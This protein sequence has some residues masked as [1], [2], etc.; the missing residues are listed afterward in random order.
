MRSSLPLVLSVTLLGPA[1]LA[2]CQCDDID[3][4]RPKFAPIATIRTPAD[5]TPFLVGDNV[6]VMGR[7]WS[8]YHKDDVT[9]T[10]RLGN[11]LVCPGTV[12]SSVPGGDGK[13]GEVTCNFPM[14]NLDRVPLTLVVVDPDGLAEDA[15]IELVRNPGGAPTATI[16]APV[17]GQRYYDGTLIELRGHVADPEDDPTDLSVA[18]LDGTTPLALQATALGSGDVLSS[19]AFTEGQHVLQLTVQDTMGN[20]AADQVIFDVGPPNRTPLCAIVAPEDGAGLQLGLPLTL[21]GTASDADI[22]ATALQVEWSSQL[23]GVLGTGGPVL[24]GDIEAPVVLTAGV[25]AIRLT[26]TDD[27]GAVCVDQITV[28]VGTP[29][30]VTITGPTPASLFTCNTTIDFTATISDPDEAPQ[31]LSVAWSSSMDGQMNTDPSDPTGS[32]A[33]QTSSLSSGAHTVFLDVTDRA[34]LTTRRSVAIAVNCAPEA[35]VISLTPASPTTTDTLQAIVAVAATDADGDPLTATWAWTRDGQPTTEAGPTVASALTSKNQTWAVTQQVTD[36]TL[37]ATSAPVSVVI[38]NT[39]PVA[40][41]ASIDPVALTVASSPNCLLSGVADAD[42]DAVT[43]SVVWW[44]DGVQVAT[45]TPLSASLLQRGQSMHCVATPTD[46]TDVGISH[47]SASVE[48]QNTLP[49]PPAV[50]ITPAAP[51][52]GVDDLWC[53]ISTPSM[54]ADGDVVAYRFTWT[55]DGTPLA[56]TSDNVLPGDLVPA[57]FTSPGQVWTCAVEASDGFG[58]SP[59]ATASVTTVCQPGPL[60]C[61][62]VDDDCDNSLIDGFANLDGDGLPDCIDDDADGDGSPADEDCDDFDADVRPGLFDIPND[63]TDQDCSGA[64]ATLCYIDGDL[65]GYGRDCTPGDSGHADDSAHDSGTDDTDSSEDCMVYAADGDCDDPGEATDPDDCDDANDA[66]SPAGDD[67]CNGVDDDC[68]GVED[69]GTEPAPL[70]TLQNGV[71]AGATKVCVAGSWTDPNY[72]TH[73]PNYQTIET[74]CDGWN[75]D[76]D[77]QTDENV[78]VG[79]LANLQAGVCAGARKVCL[80]GA[81]REPSYASYSGFYESTESS[82]DTRDNDCD[83]AVDENVK[84][85]W[86]ADLDGDSFGDPDNSQL[87]CNDPGAAWVSDNRDCDDGWSFVRPGLV[88]KEM[89]SLRSDL[90]TDNLITYNGDIEYVELTTRDPSREDYYRDADPLVLGYVVSH[91]GQTSASDSSP[92]TSPPS[93]EWVR[94]Q[95]LW[96]IDAQDPGQPI[97]GDHCVQLEGAT[98]SSACPANPTSSGF[99]GWVR[100]SDNMGDGSRTRHWYKVYKASHANHRMTASGSHRDDLVANNGFVDAGTAGWILNGDFTCPP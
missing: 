79:P 4:S 17:S 22:D 82:C 89:V 72:A 11:D 98:G 48:V 34:G 56:Q 10:W 91:F 81:W 93:S 13:K 69:N 8:E 32:V 16:S 25:H 58:W 20:T 75:N 21:Q 95:R 86:Y 14:P 57:S 74:L 67:V 94:I 18:W 83:G 71:C 23:D 38:R 26:V 96:Y 37:T 63:G 54:D 30:T 19:A 70:A 41:G 40:T 39:P 29:P 27:A 62:D 49:T 55:V 100:R 7:A 90:R 46:G 47:T 5:G 85:R 9:V 99:Y 66:V 50:T 35:P 36:G 65:D 87:A 53:A 60:V 78:G 84:L 28:E 6:T 77:G 45:G 76:C 64:D 1:W 31:D 44:I 73:S 61:D 2:G 3:I 68:D 51:G 92:R 59:P 88:M 15:T 12:P 52:A 24:S 80:T 43:T 97:F 42:A 33:F